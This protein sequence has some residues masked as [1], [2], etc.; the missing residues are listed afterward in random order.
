MAKFLKGNYRLPKNKG[1]PPTSSRSSKSLTE[2]F[3]ETALSKLGGS[4]CFVVKKKTFLWNGEGS[5]KAS[6]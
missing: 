5:E 1:N 4:M 3:E 2:Q 6:P